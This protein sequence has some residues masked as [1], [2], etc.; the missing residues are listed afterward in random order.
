MQLQYDLKLI[1]KFI[2][3]FYNLLRYNVTGKEHNFLLIRYRRNSNSS[4]LLSIEARTIFL[5]FIVSGFFIS[6]WNYNWYMEQ[7]KVP[8]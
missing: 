4:V 2:C 1:L 7:K 8:I 5:Q 3:N 6:N